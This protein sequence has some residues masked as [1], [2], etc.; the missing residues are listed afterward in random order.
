[1]CVWCLTIHWRENYWILFV[2]LLKHVLLNQMISAYLLTR[3]IKVTV[4]WSSE[5]SS[6]EAEVLYGFQTPDYVVCCIV[7]A[8]SIAIGLYY[9]FSGGKQSTTLEYHLGNRKL[10]L[11]PVILSLVITNQSPVGLVGVPA[12][13]YFYGM[14]VNLLGLGFVIAYLIASRIVVPLVYPLKITS[15]NEV[16]I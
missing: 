10:K 13:V 7:I 3:L 11:I 6:T 16:R 12:E 15:V 5:M 4:K 2:H 8:T 14:Q 1:M 9:A